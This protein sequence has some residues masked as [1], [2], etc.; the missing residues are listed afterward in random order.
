MRTM[1]YPISLVSKPVSVNVSDIQM[2]F[3]FAKSVSMVMIKTG[4]VTAAHE[5]MPIRS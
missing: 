4:L 2:I 1:N 5:L 3:L